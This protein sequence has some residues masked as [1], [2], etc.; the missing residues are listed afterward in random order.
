MFKLTKD[1][2]A[3]VARRPFI[4]TIADKREA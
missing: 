4:D 2:A 1:E 3:D